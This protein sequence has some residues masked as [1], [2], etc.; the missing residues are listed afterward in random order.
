MLFVLFR[1]TR[2]PLTRRFT[3]WKQRTREMVLTRMCMTS[4]GADCVLANINSS[5]AESRTK[6]LEVRHSY[7]PGSFKAGTPSLDMDEPSTYIAIQDIDLDDVPFRTPSKMYKGTSSKLFNQSVKEET[8]SSSSSEEDEE[9][10]QNHKAD[11]AE[12]TDDNG[13][14]ESFRE[15]IEPYAV[16]DIEVCKAHQIP[17]LTG[18]SS[19]QS[20]SALTYDYTDEFKCR[21]KKKNSSPSNEYIDKVKR[22]GSVSASSNEFTPDVDDDRSKSFRNA[23]HRFEQLCFS[24]VNLQSEN[25]ADRCV[26]NDSSLSMPHTIVYTAVDVECS[27]STCPS[28]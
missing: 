15:L 22:P 13:D 16:V 12:F 10:S 25:T 17:G 27:N 7:H 18:C 2:A 8:N 23:K 19:D 9:V 3:G 28:D 11:V 26:T 1:R 14:K 6:T 5:N 21:W 24:S 4:R 20:P